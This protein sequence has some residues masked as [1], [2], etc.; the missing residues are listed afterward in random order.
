MSIDLRRPL[1]GGASQ[2]DNV[3]VQRQNKTN[4]V[5]FPQWEIL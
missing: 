4:L 5:G 3:K 1:A 2:I